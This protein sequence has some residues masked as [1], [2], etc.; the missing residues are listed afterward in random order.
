MAALR[1]RMIWPISSPGNVVVG[2]HLVLAVAV[3][4]GGISVEHQPERPV[5]IQR[6]DG[7]LQHEHRQNIDGAE[8]DEQGQLGPLDD[9]VIEGLRDLQPA[10]QTGLRD[11]SDRYRWNPGWTR[12]RPD[13]RRASEV[14]LWSRL[15]FLAVPSR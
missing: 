1:A 9:I 10:V 12:P 4:G 14:T 15:R 13:V 11:L 8:H 7:G 5:D 3:L 6:H 2:D